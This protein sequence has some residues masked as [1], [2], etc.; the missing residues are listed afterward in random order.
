VTVTDVI[1]QTIGH[2][3]SLRELNCC[4]AISVS[5][6]VLLF[7]QTAGGSFLCLATCLFVVADS[8]RVMRDSLSDSGAL[9]A[10][11]CHAILSSHSPTR[12]QR[13]FKRTCSCVKTISLSSTYL[14][15]M[16]YSCRDVIG[17]SDLR[18]TDQRPRCHQAV[19]ALVIITCSLQ[20]N[21]AVHRCLRSLC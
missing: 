21:D 12:D 18:P 15:L 14:Y 9:C 7:I 17:L 1:N 16:Y 13:S 4:H 6:C 5:W 20:W 3:I 8:R 11:A 2:N 19:E 10:G